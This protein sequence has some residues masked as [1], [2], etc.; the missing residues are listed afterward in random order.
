MNRGILFLWLACVSH[1]FCVFPIGEIEKW[2]E[3][4][5]IEGAKPQQNKK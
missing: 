1:F 3:K 2:G 4:G 5:I